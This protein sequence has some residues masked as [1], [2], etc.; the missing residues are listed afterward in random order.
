[1]VVAHRAVG[2]VGEPEPCRK[3]DVYGEDGE[4]ANL[5][6]FHEFAAHEV[7]ESAVGVAPVGD[8][9]HQV[10]TSVEED[11]H[12]QECTCQSHE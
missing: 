12:Q 3:D 1:M 2:A 6:Y 10:G 9:N 11:K 7:A 5:Y 8:E 4:E